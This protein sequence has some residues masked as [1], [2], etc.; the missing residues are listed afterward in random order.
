MMSLTGNAVKDTYL[1]LVQLEQSGAGLPSHAG[2]HAKLYDGDGNQIISSTGRR[3]WLNNDP[4]ATGTPTEECFTAKNQT[5]LLAEGWVKDAD[6][7]I[8]IADGWFQVT[9]TANETDWKAV[10]FPVSL[11]GD[12]EFWLS[13]VWGTGYSSSYAGLGAIGLAVCDSVND[14]VHYVGKNLTNNSGVDRYTGSTIANPLGGTGTQEGNTLYGTDQVFR[15]YRSSGTVGLMCCIHGNTI[16]LPS[17]ALSARS[18]WSAETTVA[19]A[20]TFDRVYVYF[21]AAYAADYKAG[22]RFLRRYV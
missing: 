5:T 16:G 21:R 15:V 10:Y 13:P 20:R 17:G 1:D 8:E 11:T 2:K 7:A 18:M 4:L 22:F 12:F 19:D 9:C 3:G 14:V 6:F